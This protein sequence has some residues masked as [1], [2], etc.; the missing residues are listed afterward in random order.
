MQLITKSIRGEGR[1]QRKQVVKDLLKRRDLAVLVKLIDDDRSA[2]GALFSFLYEKDQQL[3]WRAIEGV[4]YVAAHFFSTEPETVRDWIRR[5]IWAMNEESGSMAWHAP[6][7]IS[8]I[9]IR[10]PPLI[11]EYARIMAS[12]IDEPVFRRSVFLA[13]ARIAAHKAAYF[14]DLAEQFAEALTE[15]DPTIRGSAALLLGALGKQSR[16]KEHPELLR[17]GETIPLYD[18]RSGE[19]GEITVSSIVGGVMEGTSLPT[20]MLDYN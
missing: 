9:V 5:Q 14:E 13:S 20:L 11:K 2:I 1:R 12:N 15:D 10:V 19:M 4:G 3:L 6:E 7:T 17:D 16:F 18:F 8:E